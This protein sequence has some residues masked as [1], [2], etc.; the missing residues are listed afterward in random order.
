MNVPPYVIDMRV[1]E[2]SR[3][4]VHLWIPLFLLWPLLLVIGVLA[5][6]LT[7]LADIALFMLG[8]PYH[9]YTL[10]LIGCFALTTELRGTT[11][12]VRSPEALVDLTLK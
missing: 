7:L 11:V 8:R 6:V 2:A 5:I 10:F 3:A 9:Y 4:P 1:A 12:H